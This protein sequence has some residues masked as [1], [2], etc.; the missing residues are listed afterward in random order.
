MELSELQQT[1]RAADPAAVLLPPRALDR[2]IQQALNLTGLFPRIP[3]RDCFVVD[4][5]TLFRHVEQ[6]ELNLEP[7]QLLPPTVILLARPT[8]EELDVA[9]P[10]PLLVRYWRSLFHGAVHRHLEERRREGRL[11]AEAV[12]QRVDQIGPVAFEEA[13]TVLEQDGYL[14]PAADEPAVFIEFAAVFL[15]LRRFAPPL[16]AVWFPAVRDPERIDDLLAQ[17]VPAMELFAQTRPPG[18]PDPSTAAIDRADEAHEFYWKLIRSAVS[19]ARSG[20]LV[21]AAILRRRAARV[22]PGG[23]ALDT[24]READEE[25]RRLSLRLQA[26]LQ[27]SD[28]ET[29]EWQKDLPTLLDKADQGSRP[30]EAALLFDLQKLCVDYERNLYTLDV[31]EWLLSAGKRPIKRPLPG[32]R[33][34]RVTRHLRRAAQRLAMARLSEADRQHLGTLLHSALR[35]S[36]DRLR[37]RFRPLLIDAL[38]NVGLQPSNLPE[39]IAFHKIVEELLDRIAEHGHFTFGDLRDAISRNQ[40]KLPDL[41]DPQDFLRGDPLLRLD[42]RLTTLL[43]GIYRPSEAYVRSLQRLSA[44]NFGTAAG[45]WLTRYVTL[46]FGGAFLVVEGVTRLLEYFDFLRPPPLAYYSTWLLLGV[47]L[48]GLLHSP[49]LR[50]WFV[51]LA[52]SVG[53]PLYKAFVEVPA[54][55]VRLPVLR[56]LAASWPFQLAVWYLLKPLVACA[57]LA[58]AWPE[59]FGSWLGALGV[60]LAATLLLNSRPGRAVE[61]ILVRLAIGFYELL[62]AGLLPGLFRL[63]MRLFK[64]FI[65]LVEGVRFRV[66]EWLWFRSGESRWTAVARAVLRL[67]WFPVS[68]VARF[69]IVVLVEPGFNP[70]K[71]PISSIAAKF[72]Y[73]VVWPLTPLL[74]VWLSPVLGGPLAYVVVM[75]TAFLL[76]DVFGFLVWELKENWSLYRANRSATLRPAVVGRRG[77]TVRRLLQPGFHS[78]TVPKLFARLRQAERAAVRTGSRRSVRVWQQE[79][80]GVEEAVRRFTDRELVAVLNQSPAWEKQRLSV[81][82]VMLACNR[83]GIE[84]LV[85]DFPDQPLELDIEEE[86]GWLVA[87]IPRRG[88][89]D[90][91]S[92]AQRDALARALAIFYKFAGVDLV[93]EQVRARLPASVACYDITPQG[94]V[95][96][97]DHRNGQ[98]L[99]CD[100]RG[101]N[102]EPHGAAPADRLALDCRQV[103]FAQTPLTWDQ[104]VSAWEKA[105]K[106]QGLP[107]LLDTD[108]GSVLPG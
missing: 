5:A 3:H 21:R 86:A 77:E 15:E 46:P 104:W 103:V 95:L 98:A 88:W 66:D 102:G 87:G 92:S 12:R 73:P 57:L 89:L 36:E 4:R 105:P 31:V 17:E 47:F 6:E 27:F 45:R 69:Y 9:D 81:G 60:F 70:I 33:L 23:L 54:W 80:E 7:D 8:A 37:A 74:V 72:V 29:A 53:R 97:L 107:P 85:N 96:W 64:Q 90:R 28:A 91:A 2:V 58:L 75:T 78:G 30:V 38:Q 19:A 83:I 42:R 76:P 82:R 71:F 43:D 26:A 59:P 67:L 52:R 22:A 61:E 44:L 49:E 25:L 79:L 99:T 20:N 50:A 48:L 94:L 41:R 35:Q 93:R 40:L 100:L 14:L 32:Q 63:M 108:K 39:R 101:A 11:T 34:V 106:G 1:L 84:L 65:D 56:R 68:Y 18:A 16:V 24:R 62:R 55:L 10:G 51:R 13:R